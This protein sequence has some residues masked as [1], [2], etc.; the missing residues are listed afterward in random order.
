MAQARAR[1]RPRGVDEGRALD[2]A[3]RLFRAEGYDGAPVD[4]L[5]REMGMPRATLYDRFGGKEGLFLAAVA[6]YADTRIAPVLAALGPAGALREDLA[7]FYEAVIALAT[8]DREAPGCLVSC[9]LADAKPARSNPA[10]RRTIRGETRGRV[11]VAK[12]G[13]LRV[14]SRGSSTI[15]P[16]RVPGPGACPVRRTR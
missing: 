1:G 11:I 3:V 4:R 8:A 10:P 9:A 16:F 15:R 2:A 13:S 5:C 7:A 14:C 6:R 12:W